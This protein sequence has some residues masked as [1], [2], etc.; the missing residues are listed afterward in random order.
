MPNPNIDL[1]HL[2]YFVAVAEHE[3]ISRA[4][5][6]LHVSQ[7]PL[8]RQIRDLEA[9]LGVALFRRD[10]QR[11][12]LTHPGELFLKEAKQVLE[13]FEIAVVLTREMA[14][15]DEKKV[16]VG[17]SASAAIQALPRI[18]SGFQQHHPDSQVELRTMT[19]LAMA[20]LLRR[21]E[22]DV[23]LTIGGVSEDIEEFIV[24]EI[25][26]YGLLV[27]V[28][29]QHLLS[30]LDRIPLSDVA[31]EPIISVSRSAFRWYNDYVAGLL[32]PYK[33]NFR[34]TEEHDRA[35]GVIAS[36]EAG[37]GIGF[38]YD[39]MAR[40]I[41]ERLILRPLTPEPPRAPLVVFHR[42]EPLSAAMRGFVEAAQ[43]LKRIGS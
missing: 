40:V 32:R 19:T 38:F 27:G 16:R 3:S 1:R 18:L 33:A 12:T 10:P 2:R 30:R 39:V 22:L 28:P 4:A 9:E 36:V 14:R 25:D 24:E 6:R 41:G 37:R 20:D 11:L 13:R 42:R 15:R 5:K 23:C 7:P 17:H 35:D 29:R 8:S 31:G 21:G 34:I 26:T 43:H